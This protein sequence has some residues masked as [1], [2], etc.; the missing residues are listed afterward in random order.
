MFGIMI[1]IGFLCIKLSY[2]YVIYRIGVHINGV[3]PDQIILFIGAYTLMAG[4][5]ATFFY[6]NFIRLPEHVRTGT[7]DMMMTKPISLQFMA[8]LRTIDIGYSIPNLVGGI[9]LVVF[10]WRRSGIPFTPA[11]TAGFIGFLLLGVVLTYAIFLIPQL[12]SFWT[13]KTGGVNEISNALFDFNQMPMSIYNKTIQRAGTFVL[14][15]FL[16]TNLSP[17]YVMQ[18]LSPGQLLWGLAAPV[19][20]LLITRGIWRIAIR[21]YTSAS[22]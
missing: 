16:I 20:F 4:L 18:R 11:N 7:L 19:L 15:V 3:S 22:S 13:V 2:A 10:G 5:Y 12:I 9:L 8:T 21:S 14:P 1:E 17:L 6:S